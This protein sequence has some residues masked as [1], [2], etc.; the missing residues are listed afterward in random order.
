MPEQV[1]QKAFG[2][3]GGHGEVFSV[4]ESVT[5]DYSIVGTTIRKNPQKPSSYISSL[6]Y[7]NILADGSVLV[8][9]MFG[10]APFLDVYAAA[11][12]KDGTVFVYGINGLTPFSDKNDVWLLAIEKSGKLIWRKPI[13]GGSD[14]SAA[15]LYVDSNGVI[16]LIRE[17]D[18]NAR[19]TVQLTSFDSAGNVTAQKEIYDAQKKGQLHFL[20]D[21]NWGSKFYLVHISE[22]SLLIQ[23][24]GS[25]GSLHW[26][27][28]LPFSKAKIGNSVVASATDHENFLM[29]IKSGQP[30]LDFETLKYSASNLSSYIFRI[31]PNKTI[32]AKQVFTSFSE[33]FGAEGYGDEDVTLFA[34]EYR[35]PQAKDFKYAE[36]F[37]NG[38]LSMQ[39]KW[40]FIA[41]PQTLKPNT[42][43][44]DTMIEAVDTSPGYDPIIFGTYVTEAAPPA[45]D[46]KSFLVNRMISFSSQHAKSA[47]LISLFEAYQFSSRTSNGNIIL[48][49]QAGPQSKLHGP[50]FRRFTDWGINQ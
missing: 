7:T 45:K 23:Q 27:E 24:L 4:F 43:F 21:K 35:I 9:K 48:I 46:Y 33:I 29:T 6:V 42:V 12:G 18:L 10:G 36:R 41:D 3:H 15:N 19:K 37:K 50:V 25:N 26:E 16:R 47:K 39:Q 34:N 20:T 2:N 14:A 11:Q 30:N 49:T 44:H 13:P 40:N 38:V 31:S 32:K 1:I 17:I 5:E 28:T 8:D 22:G